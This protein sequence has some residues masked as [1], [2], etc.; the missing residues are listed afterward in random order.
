MPGNV[1]PDKP[2]MPG[3]IE[4]DKPSMPAEDPDEGL[5]F[6][7]GGGGGTGDYG[8][9]GDYGQY[10][11]G[12][13]DDLDPGI[14]G[15]YDI[16]DL[17]GDPPPLD[18][19][20]DL[21]PD[22]DADPVMYFDQVSTTTVP[23]DMY[24]YLFAF[25]KPSRNRVGNVPNKD[26]PRKKFNAQA[27][28]EAYAA[29]LNSSGDKSKR[30]KKRSLWSGV[31]QWASSARSSVFSGFEDILSRSSIFDGVES[32]ARQFLQ[33]ITSPIKPKVF[34]LLDRRAPLLFRQNNFV[35]ISLSQFSIVSTGTTGKTN[36]FLLC[37]KPQAM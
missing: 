2:S 28:K 7:G 26:K 5:T 37:L 31:S 34:G 17:Y 30:R 8:N 24:D 18:N 22:Y 13:T 23:P 10:E 20:E 3:N 1:E 6:G 25:D 27:L 4:D 9:Y 32:L 33:R 19:Y 29:L 11:T 14:L 35:K 21:L 16:E 36:S 15:N 12:N